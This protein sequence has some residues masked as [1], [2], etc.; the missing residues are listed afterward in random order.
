L[1]FGWETGSVFFFSFSPFF[2]ARHG[3]RRIVPPALPPFFFFSVFSWRRELFLFSSHQKVRRSFFSPS[4]PPALF[5]SAPTEVE[6]LPFPLL[7]FLPSHELEKR[8]TFL[9]FFFL[10][11]DQA[12]RKRSDLFFPPCPLFSSLIGCPSS[13]RQDSIGSH[14]LPSCAAGDFSSSH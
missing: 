8:R 7:F 5:F 3:L 1:F 10:L 6:D 12:R 14:F 2:F 9:L 4:F 11:Y 13:T